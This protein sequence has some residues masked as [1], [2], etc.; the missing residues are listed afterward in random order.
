MTNKKQ[1]TTSLHP[2]QVKVCGLTAIEEAVGCVEMG[3]NA[4]GLVFYPQSSR[5]VGFQRG[6]AI[7]AAVSGRAVTVGVFV[8]ESFDTI[9][10]TVDNCG[11]GIVQL[12]GK[13]SPQ[14]VNRL[15]NQDLAVVKALF[16]SRSPYFAEASDFEASAFLLECG[17]GKQPGGNAVSWDWQKARTVERNTPLILAGGLT[18]QN[19][20]V[21]IHA[22]TP[23]AVDV[24][25]GVESAPGQK[26][27][28][29][30]NAFINMVSQN[31]V[32]QLPRRIF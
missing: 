15:R 20:S 17:S 9:M 27:I 2:V 5:F 24:S 10:R 26:D 25:T 4:I 31:H 3:V 22:A 23:D 32:E 13:E 12:H 21:A 11:L 16:L 1:S 14:L 30:I 19:V 18:P 6:A 7:T 28:S 8:D 29:K